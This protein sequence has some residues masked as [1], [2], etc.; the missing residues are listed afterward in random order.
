[1]A[2]SHYPSAS[3]LTLPAYGVLRWSVTVM[4]ARWM[5]FV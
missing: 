1:M 2:H 3:M 4:Q 5:S